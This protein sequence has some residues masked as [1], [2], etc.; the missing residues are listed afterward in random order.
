MKA[1]ASLET[2]IFETLPI[3]GFVAGPVKSYAVDPDA[4]VL[5]YHL[6]IEKDKITLNGKPLN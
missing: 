5:E 1:D 6:A 3:L 4:S 2:K